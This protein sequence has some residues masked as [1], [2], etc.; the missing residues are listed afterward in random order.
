MTNSIN[1]FETFKNYSTA[2]T[3]IFATNNESSPV[4]ES[5]IQALSPVLDSI[6]DKFEPKNNKHIEPKLDDFVLPNDP[7]SK[8]AIVAKKYAK[9][10]KYIYRGMKGDT[11][12]NFYEFMTLSKVPYFIG[13][14]VLALMFAMGKTKSNPEASLSAAKRFKQI[15]AGVI[16]YYLGVQLAKKVVSVPVKI[17]RGIDL[18]QP[19]QH[20]NTCKADSASGHSP[21]RTEYHEVP[22]SIDFTRWDFIHGKKEENGKITY[23]NRDK[24]ARKFGI[25]KNV[26]D[27]DSTLK[28]AITRLLVSAKACQYMLAVPFVA[29][30]VGLA[31]QKPWTEIGTGFGATF[32]KMISMNSDRT[33]KERI[34]NAGEIIKSNLTKPL[35]NSFK[36][37]WANKMGKAIILTSAIAPVLANIRILQLTSLSNNKFIDV[38]DYFR[39]KKKKQNV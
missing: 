3:D 15:G 13:G 11:D 23:T 9:L 27:A 8:T 30:G 22:E 17:F 4:A 36:L 31:G 18:E 37:L 7:I 10:P 6:N 1:F 35:N 29:L 39:T 38:S 20:I 34:R 19:F 32:K 21:K 26:Q 5:P 33:F 16:L 25:D 28:G 2:R 12:S 14:P 24:L